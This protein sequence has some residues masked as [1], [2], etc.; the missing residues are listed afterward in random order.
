MKRP[1]VL[2]LDIGTTSTIGILIRPP[3]E[4]LA[5]ASRP[6]TLRSDHVG[7]AEEDPEQWWS[8][9]GEI[10]RELLQATG[11]S[12]AEIAGVGALEA[13]RL[14]G[15]FLDFAGAEDINSYA[16]GI[17]FGAGEAEKRNI[18]LAF[19]R[20]RSFTGNDEAGGLFDGFEKGD[21]EFARLHFPIG[22]ER[23]LDLVDGDVFGKLDARSFGGALRD[24][25]I[26]VGGEGSGV[27][28]EADELR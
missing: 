26:D 7:W 18:H 8:N 16:P 4:T 23:A 27:F 24:F 6:V 10:V 19:A 21:E 17:T 22:N 13:L 11:I 14:H 25:E 15:V 2:G 5:V 3:D 1:C 12:A 9:V 28:T 20:Q